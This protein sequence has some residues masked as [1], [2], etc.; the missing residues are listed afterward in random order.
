MLR[1]ENLAAF[2]AA[3]QCD[4]VFP[5]C[6]RGRKQTE[7]FRLHVG[8][9][10]VD[11]ANALGI[12]GSRLQDQ[13]RL[14]CRQ[15]FEQLS[16]ILE[17]GVALRKHPPQCRNDFLLSTTEFFGRFAKQCEIAARRFFGTPAANKLHAP[18]LPNPHRAPHKDHADLSGAFYVGPAARC[19]STPSISIARNTPSRSTSF[20]TP[21]RVNSSAVP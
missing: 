8:E 2:H 18:I 12:S 17:M 3:E 5:L 20:R 9:D 16:I 21:K 7:E 4:G 11:H 6:E 19:N 13:R 14:R 1:K 15:A 10:A